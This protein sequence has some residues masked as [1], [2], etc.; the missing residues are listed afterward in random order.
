MV[1]STYY[2]SDFEVVENDYY[3]DFYG[4]VEVLVHP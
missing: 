2:F 4:M 1:H 3:F